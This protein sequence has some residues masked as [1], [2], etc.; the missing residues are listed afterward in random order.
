MSTETTLFSQEE[1]E[2]LSKRGWAIYDEKLKSILEPEFN[3][4]IVAIH[5]D[6]G[7]YEVANNSPT[8]SR[9]IRARHP[10]GLM[11]VTD[12]G[13]ARMDGLTLRMMSSQMISERMK[14]GERK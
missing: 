9:A 3:G 13:P 5:L 1:L 8:A 12:I 7:D 2:Q 4:K 6:T 14:S 10:E 11:M